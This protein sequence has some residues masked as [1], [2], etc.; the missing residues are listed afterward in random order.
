M[1]DKKERIL[2]L[3]K[4]GKTP[5]EV[6]KTLNIRPQDVYN[7]A[8]LD[9][10]RKAKLK[11][12]RAVVRATAKLRKKKITLK[13]KPEVFRWVN[14]EAVDPQATID[15]LR[16]EIVGYKAVISYLEHRLGLSST[17]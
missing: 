15:S 6:A 11:I 14:R 5:K 1:L 3:L 12:Q 2:A 4:E 7:T 17:Q 10:K 9:R 13:K 8:Y 16:H